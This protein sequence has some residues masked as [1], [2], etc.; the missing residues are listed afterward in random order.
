MRNQIR[1]IAATVACSFRKGEL[2]AIHAEHEDR[3]V[4]SPVFDEIVRFVF[5]IA[6]R[7]DKHVCPGYIEHHQELI[8]IDAANFCLSGEV[9]VICN[10]KGDWWQLRQLSIRDKAHRVR[11]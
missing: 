7:S 10:S 4:R 3:M 5:V 2:L 9:R 8:Q 1:S 11:G 6:D